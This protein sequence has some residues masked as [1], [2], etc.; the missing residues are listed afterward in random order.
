MKIFNQCY[1]NKLT[2]QAHGEPRKRKHHNI[3]ESYSDPCQR[4]FNAIEPSSYIRP[5]M[6]SSDPKDELLIAIRG[7]MALVTFDEHGIM[8]RVIRFA[9][10]SNDFDVAVGVEVP[11]NTWHTVV[12]LEPG[13]ILLEIKTGPFDPKKPKDLALWAPDENGPD[14]KHYL[15]KLTSKVI[16]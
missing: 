12:S 15:E 3:H 1:L 14:A 11:A 5:H 9:A 4:L 7:V 6:H 10:G 2:M 16:G 13:S 8:A